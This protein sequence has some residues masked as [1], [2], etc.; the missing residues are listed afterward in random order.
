MA[1]VVVGGAWML[2]QVREALR[3]DEFGE[4]L[5]G[6]LRDGGFIEAGRAG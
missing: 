5:V 2:W 3:S 4:K 1:G 6:M